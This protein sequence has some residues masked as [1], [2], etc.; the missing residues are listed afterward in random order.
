MALIIG[1]DNH[2]ELIG[3]NFNDTID[4]GAGDDTLMGLGFSD[5]FHTNPGRD[6]FDGGSGDHDTITFERAS[7]RAIANL[8]TGIIFSDGLG[9]QDS[10]ALNTVEN[11]FGSRFNDNFVGDNKSN[12]L[13]G[14]NGNDILNGLGGSDGL[15]GGNGNDTLIGGSG[16]D[17]LIGDNRRNNTGNGNDFLRGDSGNDS[18]IGGNGNDTLIGGSG[19]DTLIGGGGNDVLN[20]SGGNDVLVGGLGADRFQLFGSNYIGVPRAIVRDFNS[21]QNDKI[22]VNGD[23]SRYSFEL[24]INL[25]R[26]K[27]DNHLIGILEGVTAFD[28]STGP[29]GNVEVV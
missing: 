26:V 25:V 18:L 14:F 29:G 17:T 23:I 16:N 13:R 11:L 5:V 6:H 9:G 7:G 1:N 3:T 19:N 15:I 20:G 27:F 2:E 10:I 12:D 28:P 22:V 24:G 4:G 21:L 8:S